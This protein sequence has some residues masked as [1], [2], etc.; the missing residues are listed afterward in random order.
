MT[1][2]GVQPTTTKMP[3]LDDSYGNNDDN[4]KTSVSLLKMFDLAQ[5]SEAMF[6]DSGDT[7]KDKRIRT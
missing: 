5:D 4:T 6:E 3:A 7:N 1:R 2:K